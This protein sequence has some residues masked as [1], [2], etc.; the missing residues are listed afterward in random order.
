MDKPATPATGATSN[1]ARSL[2]L[3]IIALTH[4]L[5]RSLITLEAMSLYGGTALHST[6][7]DL[8]HDHGLVFDRQ[9]EPHQHRN[10]GKT[11]F[12]RYTLSDGSRE[13]AE[14]LVKRYKRART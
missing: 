8:T 11:H 6:I 2:P 7:S 13:A 5:K 1:K 14:S 10:G 3:K 9:M 12:M 4:L